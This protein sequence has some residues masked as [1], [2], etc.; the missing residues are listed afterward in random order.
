MYILCAEGK[1]SCWPR[2]Q[3]LAADSVHGSSWAF[4]VIEVDLMPGLFNKHG[5]FNG[6]YDGFIRGAGPDQF[7]Q[8]GFV[9]RK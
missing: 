4:E 3:L 6:F 1:L 2:A 5:L 9:C 7:F 8:I